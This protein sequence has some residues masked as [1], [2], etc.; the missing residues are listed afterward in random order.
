M[1]RH[2][3]LEWRTAFQTALNPPERQRLSA[4]RPLTKCSFSSPSGRWRRTPQQ[5]GSRPVRCRAP[6]L[7]DEQA[8]PH[9]PPLIDEDD[10]LLLARAVHPRPLRLHYGR[11]SGEEHGLREVL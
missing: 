11:L 1:P 4:R 10:V 2:C 5:A 3:L 9:D 7:G 6:R 8:P